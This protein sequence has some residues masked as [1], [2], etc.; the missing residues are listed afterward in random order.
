LQAK[1]KNASVCLSFP[2]G[3]TMAIVKVFVA[4]IS[5]GFCFALLGLVF[6]A[7]FER[8]FGTVTP[9][10]ILDFAFWGSI[11]GGLAVATQEI[12]DAIR[13]TKST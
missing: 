5:C 2:G 4:A 12:V 6:A 3:I 8:S 13:K 11:L 7:T 9:V 10:V 1:G